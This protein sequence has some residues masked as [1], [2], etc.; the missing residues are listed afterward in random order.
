[1]VVFYVPTSL[2]DDWSNPVVL[3]G[4]CASLVFHSHKSKHTAWHESLSP[5]TTFEDAFSRD[6]IRGDT[7]LPRPLADKFVPTVERA[8]DP[9]V[10]EQYA[11]E[12]VEQDQCDHTWG[13]ELTTCTTCGKPYNEWAAE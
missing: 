6:D 4:E 5:A 7:R 2:K 10:T 1:M 8:P 9:S 12:A 11:D 3:C 13:P